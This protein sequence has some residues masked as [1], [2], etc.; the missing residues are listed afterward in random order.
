MKI[1]LIRHAT[2]VVEYA[3]KRILVDPMLSAKDQLDPV[4]G[5]ANSLRNPLVDLKVALEEILKPDL[6]LVTHTHRDHFDDA[7]IAKLSKDIPLYCQP[8]DLKKISK[9][10]FTE[11]KAVETSLTFGD[12]EVIRTGGHHGR[13]PVSVLMGAVSGF[14]LKAKGEPTLYIVGDT[15]W[16]HEVETALD[17]HKPAV[18]VLNMGA[19]QLRMGGPI[20]MDENDLESLAGHAHATKIVAVHMDTW[21]HCL[22]KRADLKEKLKGKDYAVRV[23]I[24][25]DGDIL[26]F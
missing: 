10:G 11:A 8:H 12:I 14:V 4:P 2:L 1:R 6:V 21:N 13:G 22:L 18:A 5:A 19:A 15:I 23:Q 20:T 7:A 26:T 25:E 9:L 24:P 16:C 17:Q 3:G